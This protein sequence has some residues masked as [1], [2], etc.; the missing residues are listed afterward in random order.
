MDTQ[1]KNVRL[2]IRHMK[3]LEIAGFTLLRLSVKKCSNTNL[4]QK[5]TVP[6]VRS[7]GISRSAIFI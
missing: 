2:S 5:I 4:R 6:D 1:V 3:L 7:H